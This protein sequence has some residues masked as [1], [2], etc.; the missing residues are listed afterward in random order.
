M[1]CLPLAEKQATSVYWQVRTAR[2][3]HG[4]Q[5]TLKYDRNTNL[6]R[7]DHDGIQRAGGGLPG[8]LL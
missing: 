4:T 1:G 7:I 3:G 2:N 6:A 8:D 5:V